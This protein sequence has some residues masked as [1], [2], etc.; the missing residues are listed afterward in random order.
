MTLDQETRGD[1]TI[2]RP[3]GRLD[4]ASSPELERA[5]LERLEQGCKRMVFDLADMDYV[6]SAGLRVILLAGKKL[7]AGQ[8]RLAISGM[9]EMVR[10]VFEMSG[11]LTL[12]AVT[13][14]LDEAL[15]KV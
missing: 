6:S 1:V 12:F 10:E 13:P 9:R 15:S 2:L 7:R 4:S 8:G 14:T 11:F 3:V 5:V